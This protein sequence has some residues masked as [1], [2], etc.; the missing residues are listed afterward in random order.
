MSVRKLN[1]HV[2][3]QV[4]LCEPNTHACCKPSTHDRLQTK[5]ILIYKPSSHAH[6]QTKHYMITTRLPDNQCLSVAAAAA[7]AAAAAAVFS[8]TETI[9][10]SNSNNSQQPQRSSEVICLC[11]LT[12]DFV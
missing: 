4:I 3:L 1:T 11:R 8:A 2:Y 5:F 10:S 9:L 6:Q 12:T 7:T